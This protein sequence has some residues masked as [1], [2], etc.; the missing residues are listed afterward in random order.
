MPAPDTITVEVLY[1]NMSYIGVEGVNNVTTIDI[2]D[3]PETLDVNVSISDVVIPVTSVNGKTGAVVIDY[4]DIGTNPVNHVR[5]VHTQASIPTIQTSGTW[6]GYYIWTINHNL[7][8]YPN[9]TVF[10]SGNNVV[11]T[12]ISYSNANTAIIIMNSAIS[13]I[14]YLS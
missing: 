6:A 14:A 9:V 5:F 2:S 3:D 7:N 8:F 11:E 1:N 10:D 4:P 13:G 12:H